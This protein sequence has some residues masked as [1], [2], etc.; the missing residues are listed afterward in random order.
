MPHTRRKIKIVILG[1]GFGGVY[2]FKYLHRYFHKQSLVEILL[3]NEKNYFLFTPLLHEVA[4]GSVTAEHVVEPLQKIVSCCNTD[5]LEARVDRILTQEQKVA[6]S[7]GAILYDYLVLALGAETNYFDIPGAKEFTFSLKSLEDARALKN[8]C[9]RMFE[10]ASNTSDE[11]ERR[12]LLHFVIVGGG[13]TGVELA[14]EM[15]EFFQETLNRLYGRF[16]FERYLAVSLIERGKSLLPVFSQKMGKRALETLRRKGVNVQLET[17]VTEVGQGFLVLDA[18]HRLSCGT[19]VWVAGVKPQR[20]DF[21][22]PVEQDSRGRIFVDVT[23]HLVGQ[24]KIFAIG[25]I[26]N[27]KE[28]SKR[29]YLALAQVA[30]QQARVAAKNIVAD[31]K[32]RPSARFLYIH[33]GDLVSLGRWMAI[34]R[35][36]MIPISGRFTWLLWRTVYW[37]KLISWRKRLQV[38]LDWFANLISPR[39]ISQI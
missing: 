29:G 9:I 10:T 25:D 26:A 32:G 22:I 39:D 14:A 3:V 35:V 34:G 37:S 30:T 36:L 24:K 20:V 16:R 4:T 7:A 38:A 13:P 8:H 5:F 6:T 1:G 2:T 19:A 11:Y 15:A 21:D 28:G 17:S 33:W 12:K 31:I 23:L 18:K 27:R